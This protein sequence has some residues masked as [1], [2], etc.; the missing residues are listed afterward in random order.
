M[1]DPSYEQ[2][3]RLAEDRGVWAFYA[4]GAAVALAGILAWRWARG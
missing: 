1:S 4:T 3:A 2:L